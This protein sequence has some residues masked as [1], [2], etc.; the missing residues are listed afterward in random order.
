MSLA[1]IFQAS[2][3]LMD[4]LDKLKILVRDKQSSLFCPTMSDEEKMFYNIANKCH[5]CK[6]FFYFL[7][8]VTAEYTIVSVS[9]MYFE[10]CLIL[11]GKL[12]K[13]ESTS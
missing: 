2:Q 10:S 9:S 3:M 12:N 5:C 11:S 4:K 1:T 8:I 13:A 6:T 7:T